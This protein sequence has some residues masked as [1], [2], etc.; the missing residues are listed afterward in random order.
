MLFW[1][2]NIAPKR[3][4][5]LWIDMAAILVSLFHINYCYF[6]MLFQPHKIVPSQETEKD[7]HRYAQLRNLLSGKNKSTQEYR[8]ELE[9]NQWTLRLHEKIRV[10]V[11]HY[12][13]L[14]MITIVLLVAIMS[15]SI[16]ALGY[17][18]ICTLLIFN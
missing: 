14:F 17:I 3:M 7:L 5:G 4:N 6:W 1:S 13:Q 18:F 10:N 9:Q 16:I 2:I 12:S 15:K 11:Y 8:I